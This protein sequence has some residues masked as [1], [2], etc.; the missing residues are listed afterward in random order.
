MTGYVK[1]ADRT[2]AWHLFNR[3]FKVRINPNHL[4]TAED[5]KLYGTPTTGN[6][7]KDADLAL[8]EEVVMLNIAQMEDL[9]HQNYPVKVVNF[10]DTK[11]IYRYIS[12]HLI[13]MK[14]LFDKSE[15]VTTDPTL[16][17]DLIR[18]DQFAQAVFQFARYGLKFDILHSSL[19]RRMLT[20]DRFAAL[21][22]LGRAARKTTEAPTTTGPQPGSLRDYRSGTDVPQ[23]NPNQEASDLFVPEE[24]PTLPKRINLERLFE[25]RKK[26]GLSYR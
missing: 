15:N 21:G 19:A 9:F 16:M 14:E 7:L 10:D 1:P 3:L 25:E 17:D 5:I 11:E 20:P 22:R 8:R 6:E 24:D 13:A 23:S 2:T 12:D 4:R 26:L 18:L